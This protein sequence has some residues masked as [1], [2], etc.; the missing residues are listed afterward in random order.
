MILLPPVYAENL[1]SKEGRMR[2]EKV[3][4]SSCL[5]SVVQKFGPWLGVISKARVELTWPSKYLDL[6]SAPLPFVSMQQQPRA[7]RPLHR[8]YPVPTTLQ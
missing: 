8:I 4:L 2:K 3:L 6:L 5:N 7:T 1:A